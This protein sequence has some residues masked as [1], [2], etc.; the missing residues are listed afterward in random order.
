[1]HQ[2]INIDSKN[3]L[4][5]FFLTILLIFYFIEVSSQENKIFKFLDKN[6]MNNT[7]IDYDNDGDL[8]FI[9]VG[10]IADRNQ[11][12]VYL[13]ENKGKNFAK[14]EYIFSYP[15]IPIKQHLKIS[16]QKNILKIKIIGT[17]TKG[18]KTKYTATVNKGEFQ[19]VLIPPATSGSLKN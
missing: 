9:Y 7:K 17:S 5:R 13:V 14:P 10:V 4:L 6:T 3:S 2:I 16:L 11:G 19:G 18:I 1:M 12:R 15:T 8:D